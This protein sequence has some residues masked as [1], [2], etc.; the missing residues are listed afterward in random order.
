MTKSMFNL[1]DLF[2]YIYFVDL[3]TLRLVIPEARRILAERERT[4]ARETP[5]ASVPGSL[6]ARAH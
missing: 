6:P 4:A 5:A 1:S 2:A 3:P